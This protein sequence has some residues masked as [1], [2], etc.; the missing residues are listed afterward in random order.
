VASTSELAEINETLIQEVLQGV[1]AFKI[2][3]CDD[4][5]AP[6]NA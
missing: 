5:D 4:T 1:N 3:S 2:D 6:A